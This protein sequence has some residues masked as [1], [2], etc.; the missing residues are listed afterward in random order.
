MVGIVKSTLSYTDFVGK[1]PFINAKKYY[2]ILLVVQ[3]LIFDHLQKNFKTLFYD[4]YNSENYA[5]E[6]A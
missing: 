6:A 3:K 2:K 1:S 4:L 5:K